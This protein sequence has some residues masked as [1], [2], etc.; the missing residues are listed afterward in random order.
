VAVCA[1][2]GMGIPEC[3]AK[4]YETRL[5]EGRILV[6][7]AIHLKLDELLRG[8]A[9]ARTSLVNLENLSDEELERLQAQ[10]ERLGEAVSRRH[11]NRSQEAA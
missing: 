6:T 11:R 2:I 5:R 10:F 9:G 4:R 7:K 3:E 1:L 8:V